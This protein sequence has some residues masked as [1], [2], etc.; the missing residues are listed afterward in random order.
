MMKSIQRLVAAILFSGILLSFAG[1]V[2]PE[3]PVTAENLMNSNIQELLSDYF[4]TRVTV[5]NAVAQNHSKASVRQKLQSD[6]GIITNNTTLISIEAARLD[7]ADNL[8]KYHGVYPI[9]STNS[10]YIQSYRYNAE[11]KTTNQPV[12]YTLD[13]YEWTWIE[14]TNGIDNDINK[15]GYATEHEITV[16]K[17]DGSSDYVIVSDVYDES[18]ILGERQELFVS[19]QLEE[20]ALSKKSMLVS[21][22]NG[23]NSNVNM[24][25]NALIDYADQYVVHEYSPVMMNTS[26]YNSPEYGYYSNADCANFVSQCLRAGGMS[27]DYGTGKNN[28]NPD[29]T[30]WWYDTYTTPTNNNYNVSPLAWRYVP[31]F[32]QPFGR[33][34]SAQIGMKEC[35]QTTAFLVK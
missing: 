7:A 32:N 17:Q 9:N 21:A 8:K 18:D 13:V 20:A 19:N 1:A 33:D 2:H 30:Q 6:L 3:V 11:S 31:H 10:F 14:Y 22:T 16:C 34:A 24:D 15:M 23:I 28:E 12:S 25:V 35:R 5:L 26:Y 29:A 4:E 27:F